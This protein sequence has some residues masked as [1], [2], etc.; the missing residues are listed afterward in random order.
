MLCDDLSSPNGSATMSWFYDWNAHKG[1]FSNS[2]C[3]TD[4]A[5]HP[6]AEYVPQFSTYWSLNPEIEDMNLTYTMN[7]SFLMGYGLLPRC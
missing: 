1:S 7:A 4:N 6:G 5:L 2:G 3:G